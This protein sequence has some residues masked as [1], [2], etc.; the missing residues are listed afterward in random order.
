MPLKDIRDLNNGE[1]GYVLL[2]KSCPVKK[3]IAAHFYQIFKEHPS[4]FVQFKWKTKGP[5]QSIH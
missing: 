5:E 2:L 4:V 3:S 1:R